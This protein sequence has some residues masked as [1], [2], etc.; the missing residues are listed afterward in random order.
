MNDPFY[1]SNK[2]NE[3]FWFV[4]TT[5]LIIL[6]TWSDPHIGMS[7]AY[8]FVECKTMFL[9]RPTLEHLRRLTILTECLQPCKFWLNAYISN[10]CKF[11]LV[12]VRA[13]VW[14]KQYAHMTIHIR[15]IC[16]QRQGKSSHDQEIKECRFRGSWDSSLT[17]FC[18]L[19]NSLFLVRIYILKACLTLLPK[20]NESTLFLRNKRA[21]C[22][23]INIF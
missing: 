1:S 22:T 15:W 21:R 11:S 3:A 2:K 13:H 10:P 20:I 8:T 9:A 17:L 18:C 23:A 5:L 14:S 16:A 12:M 19:E 6:L 4:K 7:Q